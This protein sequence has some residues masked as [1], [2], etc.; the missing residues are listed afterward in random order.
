[1]Y[2]S[3]GGI[4]ICPKCGFGSASAAQESARGQLQVEERIK[5][6]QSLS[7]AVA[8]IVDCIE[9][10]SASALLAQM[11]RAETSAQVSSSYPSYFAEWLFPK[12]TERHRELD[13]RSR[14][15]D[16]TFPEDSRT[17]TLGGHDKELGHIHIIFSKRA[18]GWV[19]NEILECR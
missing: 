18:N 1:M 3:V 10:N 19:I 2:K 16:W 17:F 7:A 14:Y 4:D 15:K 13:F 11:A 5:C 8:F 6:F 12:L 9:T